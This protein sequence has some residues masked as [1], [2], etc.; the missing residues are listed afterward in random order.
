V[1]L[2][3]INKG[4]ISFPV[5]RETGGFLKVILNPGESGVTIKTGIPDFALGLAHMPWRIPEH[6]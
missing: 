4:S 2:A 1:I 3:P 5:M 6:L